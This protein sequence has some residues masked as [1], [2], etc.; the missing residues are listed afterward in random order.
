MALLRPISRRGRLVEATLGRQLATKVQSSRLDGLAVQHCMSPA[1]LTHLATALIG[2][3]V[4]IAL[5]KPDQYWTKAMVFLQGY[6]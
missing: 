5:M 1:C 3:I 2:L 4:C 6:Y